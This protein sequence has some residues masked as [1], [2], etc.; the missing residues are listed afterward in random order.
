MNPKYLLKL[1]NAGFTHSSLNEIENFP[2]P[3][4]IQ[5]I[6]NFLLSTLFYRGK[7]NHFIAKITLVDYFSRTNCFII[8][9][10]NLIQS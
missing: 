1:H 10:M 2:Q 7:M 3:Y 5:T 8:P 4:Y 9:S 6:L